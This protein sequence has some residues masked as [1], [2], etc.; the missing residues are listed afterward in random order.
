MHGRTR[1]NHGARGT[2]IAWDERGDVRVME[3]A[4][5]DLGASV[6]AKCL[7]GFEL[8]CATGRRKPEHFR[9]GLRAQALSNMLPWVMHVWW[10][11][12][13]R[14]SASTFNASAYL[15]YPHRIKD[16]R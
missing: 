9:L 1:R 4:C 2:A 7:P 5:P 14:N 13:G 16:P 12:H 3:F 8:K 6:E 10:F 11:R 15:P